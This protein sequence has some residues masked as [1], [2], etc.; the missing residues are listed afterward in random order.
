MNPRS[1][2]V[3]VAALIVWAVV[4]PLVWRDLQRRTKEEVRGPKL[5]WRLAS[6]N[7][8]GSVL[9][10]LVGRRNATP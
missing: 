6:A 9:Y 2:A 8:S 4:T 7:L 5:L 3:V 10:A 1:R